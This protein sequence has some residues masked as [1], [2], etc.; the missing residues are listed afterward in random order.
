MELS[1]C[2]AVKTLAVV[3][4]VLSGGCNNRLL[5]PSQVGRFRPTPAVNIILDSLGVA[6]E[7]PDAWDV[8]DEPLPTD[9]IALEADSALGPGDI[10]RV[11]IFELYSEGQMFT[12]DYI[13][14]E[15]GQVSIPDIGVIHAAGLTETDLEHE[16]RGILSPDILKNPSVSV[17]L[18]TSQRRMC[19]VVGDGVLRPGRFFIPRYDFRLNDALALAG[20]TRQFNVNTIYVSR[21]MEEEDNPISLQFR[22]PHR[23]RSRE[24]TRAQPSHPVYSAS[25]MPSRVPPAATWGQTADQERQMLGMATPTMQRLWRES[26]KILSSPD[27]WSRRA[28]RG[29]LITPTQFDMIEDQG[30]TN[31]SPGSTNNVAD[32]PERVEWV[33]ENGKWRPIVSGAQP[34]LPDTP[35]PEDADDEMSS[36]PAQP[37]VQSQRSQSMMNDRSLNREQKTSLLERVR[38]KRAAVKDNASSPVQPLESPDKSPEDID[39]VFQDGRWVPIGASDR[40]K[41]GTALPLS[42]KSI[43]PLDAPKTTDDELQW[44]QAIQSRLIRIPADKLQAADR[45]YNIV[46]KPGDTIHVPVV[47]Q[48]E[49]YVM[50]NVNRTGIVNITGRPMTLKMVIAAAGGLGPLAYPK[51]CEVIRRID[52][53]REEIVMVDLDKIA[54]GEQ[55]DFFIKPNDVI[56]VGTHYTSR[57]RAVLRNA[58]RAAYGFA[59][60]YDHNFSDEDYGTDVW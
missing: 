4:C 22:Q 13:V 59:F 41:T 16:I 6:E 19:S 18:L 51:L 30:V 20:G 44:E 37:T 54:A 29:E 26:E 53:N 14:R 42:D 5:D 56:N 12:N 34:E 47:M 48:G 27:S 3:L 28:M 45:R 38:N 35:I 32:E 40:E 7:T 31:E 33:F 39:W 60:V 46:I 8:A 21:R 55:P 43:I 15:T 10:I 24:V 36:E 17:A 25:V 1:R 11:S 57:W 9:I 23:P 52:G 49:C 2:T 50:G 58:F